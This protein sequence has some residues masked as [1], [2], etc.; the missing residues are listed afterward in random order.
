MEHPLLLSRKETSYILLAVDDVLFFVCF[1]WRFLPKRSRAQKGKKCGGGQQFYQRRSSPVQGI[2]RTSSWLP[3]AGSARLYLFT[4]RLQRQ[5]ETRHPPSPLAYGFA[6][7]PSP[8]PDVEVG[9]GTMKMTWKQ[10]LSLLTRWDPLIQYSIWLQLLKLAV[11]DPATAR[12]MLARRLPR[13]RYWRTWS[14]SCLRLTRTSRADT[15]KHPN[16]VIRRCVIN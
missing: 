11:N 2:P 10:I 9:E 5:R 14:K 6:A 8:E 3:T 7:G 13:E 4:T 12:K 15:L 1:K 16:S